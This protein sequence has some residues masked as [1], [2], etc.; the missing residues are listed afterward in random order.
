MW[1][2][3]QWERTAYR[4]PFSVKSRVEVCESVFVPGKPSLVG[5]ATEAE[6]FLLVILFV[7]EF[8][9]FMVNVMELC[10]IPYWGWV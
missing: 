4:S 8:G 9:E 5:T 10:M 7:Y 2:W 6:D 1:L 3:V